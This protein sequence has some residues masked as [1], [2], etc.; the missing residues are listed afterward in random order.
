VGVEAEEDLGNL[1]SNELEELMAKLQKMTM[2]ER[3]EAIDTLVTQEN[4]SRALNERSHFG[5]IK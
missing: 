3:E 2:A 5:P 4:F 1:T